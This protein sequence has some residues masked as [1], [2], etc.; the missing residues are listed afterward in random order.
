M[1]TLELGIFFD[2]TNRTFVKGLKGGVFVLPTLTDQDQISIRLQVLEIDPSG[3]SNA[4]YSIVDPSGVAATVAIGSTDFGTVY[5]QQTSFAV[6]GQYLT[7]LLDLNTSEMATAMGSATK[8]SAILAV[9]TVDSAGRVSCQ[10]GITIEKA[11]IRSGT[12][13][14]TPGATYLT[15]DQTAAIYA[16]KIGLP[17]ESITLTSPDGTHT[18]ILSCS[19]DGSFS[20]AT[21]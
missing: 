9:Q 18:V 11:L 20:T 2:I 13:T 7:G 16:K 14:P 10:R 8:I 15:A 19:D 6:D 4:P 21:T 17:S 1:A 3:G 5:A 12:P